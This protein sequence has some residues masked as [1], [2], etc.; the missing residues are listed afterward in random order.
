VIQACFAKQ[1]F[2]TVRSYPKL[3]FPEEGHEREDVGLAAYKF[4]PNRPYQSRLLFACV[5][6]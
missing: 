4:D 5:P 3:R 2:G 6:V 1:T